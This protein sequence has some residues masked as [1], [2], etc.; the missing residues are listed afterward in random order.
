MPTVFVASIVLRANFFRWK[1]S[2]SPR[3]KYARVAGR[4]SH[5]AYRKKIAPNATILA[6]KYPNSAESKCS[7]LREPI[8]TK[9]V[10]TIDAPSPIKVGSR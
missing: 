6:I 7:R 2:F 8:I 5:N 4:C 3:E 9:A 10:R 1:N